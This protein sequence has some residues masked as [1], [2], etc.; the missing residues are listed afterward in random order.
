M[1]DVG[2]LL[3]R[4]EQLLGEVEQ[5][6]PDVREAVFELLDGIDGLHRVAVNRLAEAVGSE[7]V[8]QA[9]ANDD[10]VA[11][12]LHVYGVGVEDE[13]AAA[14]AALEPIRP[15]IEGHGG[16]VEVLEAMDGVVRVRLA[17]T[18]SG[19]TA[20]AVTLREGVEAALRD[21]FPGFGGMLVEED[22]GEGH[23]P[24]GPTLV[25][26]SPRPPEHDLPLTVR[27]T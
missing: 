16:R 5:F 4:L 13:V 21:N 7:A 15:Y 20:S 17:G 1:S 19:C 23:P 24:P 11:W 10:A 14:T 2:Q 8:E 6:E 18:C 3:D 22:H 27:S 26:I 25:Q 12:L 9:R